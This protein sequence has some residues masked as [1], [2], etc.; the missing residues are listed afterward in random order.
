VGEILV[1][2]ALYYGVAGVKAVEESKAP[3][4]SG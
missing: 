1:A 2:G 4:E 3:K